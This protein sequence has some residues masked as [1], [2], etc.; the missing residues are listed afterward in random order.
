MR[1]SLAGKDFGIGTGRDHLAAAHARAR[2]EIDDVVGRAHRVLVVLDH[3]DR[4]AQVAKPFEAAQ[5]PIVV[6][7]M[8]AD[9]RLIEDVKHADQAAA[10]LPGQ[11]DALGLAAG[12][13]RGARDPA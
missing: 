5:Q 13:R 10:D 9:A 8:Q 2:T 12:K 3:E 11:A 7:R 4:V 6:A 1:L